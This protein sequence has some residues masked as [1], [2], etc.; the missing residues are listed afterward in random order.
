MDRGGLKGVRW[1]HCAG[2]RGRNWEGVSRWAFEGGVGGGRESGGVQCFAEFSDETV[3]LLGAVDRLHCLG[4]GLAEGD[5]V[6]DIEEP[7]GC[8]GGHYWGLDCKQGWRDV[9]PYQPGA[10]GGTF[11]NGVQGGEGVE[12]C[13]LHAGCAVLFLHGGDEVGEVGL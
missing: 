4:G 11:D 1:G 5:G 2:R 12:A 9:G 13:S 8:H 6:P 3:Q 7:V 10:D